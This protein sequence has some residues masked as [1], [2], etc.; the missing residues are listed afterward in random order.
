[1]RKSG[2][3]MHI[4]SLP[5][6]YGIGNFGRAAYDFVDRLVSAG[7]SMWQILPLG[8]TGFGDSPYQSFSTYAGNP[9][10]I[11][12]EK[13]IEKG[14]LKK[15]E[16]DRIYRGTDESSV[17]YHMLYQTRFSLL[18]KAYGVAKSEGFFK[19]KEYRSFLWKNEFW[20]SDYAL[21]M[22][23]KDKFSGKS[24]ME[25]P[26]KLRER[27]KEA[28][29]EFQMHNEEQV[30][31][32]QFLQY[33]FF[34]QWSELKQYAGHHGI[35]I[36]GDIPIY[37]A[38][39]SADTWANP[40]LF[41]LTDKGYPKAIAGCPPDGFAEDGQL[42]GNPL[43]DWDAHKKEGFAWWISRIRHCF[44]MVDVLRI[45]H[46]RGF[47]EYFSIP[48]KATTAA[49]GHW[50]KGPGYALFEK[51]KQ[52]IGDKRIIAEDLGYVTDSVRELVN[53]CNYPGM[54]V[55]QFAFDSRD[56]GNAADYLPHNY[57]KNAVVYTGTHDNATLLEWL[58]D[59]NKEEYRTVSCYIGA[60]KGD[61]KEDLVKGMIRTAMSSVADI[62]II[63]IQ[64][65]LLQGGECRM[66]RPS[67][68]GGN[69]KYRIRKKDLSAKLM[70]E[71]H[72]L[73]KLY[74]R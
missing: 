55:F 8:P 9:Y 16:C 28:L 60:R 73:T 59:I 11:D 10:F 47:D 7:Q 33:E 36:I 17:D 61:T 27:A 52:E 40:H 70:K 29:K 30:E 12:L 14:W 4:S 31:F 22:A 13:L 67:S 41:Q 74:A 5:S 26:K 48:Y 72:D 63:P 49:G 38:F 69:W 64:D 3:L 53:R 32:H 2:I 50:E 44:E 65:Y 66:N 56:T 62:C 43:Y 19:K 39:D 46:F 68:I 34:S 37:V 51:I 24:F 57:S 42:W 58:G 45:D 23:I 15:S 54:K 18:K 71:I 25:W 1:M 20:L 21:Y 6:K 35:E